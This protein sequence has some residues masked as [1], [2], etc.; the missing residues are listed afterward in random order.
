MHETVEPIFNFI[1]ADT[2]IWLTDANRT[3]R[4]TLAKAMER[5]ESQPLKA[6]QPILSMAYTRAS[7]AVHRVRRSCSPGSV[8]HSMSRSS[9]EEPPFPSAVVHRMGYD[10]TAQLQ[11]ELRLD[12]LQPAGQSPARATTTSSLRAKPRKSSGCTTFSPTA[13]PRCHTTPSLLELSA[14]GLSTKHLKL[15]GLHRPPAV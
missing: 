10:S 2:R 3:A 4:S 13:R 15:L 7:R 12:Y 8:H 14:R 9:T 11:Q 6:R 5:A 1:P